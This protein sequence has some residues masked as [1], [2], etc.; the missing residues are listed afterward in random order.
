MYVSDDLNY[1]SFADRFLMPR[2]TKS[3]IFQNFAKCLK[4]K[5]DHEWKYSLC[6]TVDIQILFTAL[7]IRIHKK[8]CS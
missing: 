7:K 3:L 4:T 1:L 2:G 8:F 5:H 6:V